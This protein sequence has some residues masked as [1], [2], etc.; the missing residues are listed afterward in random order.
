MS[1][2]SDGALGYGLVRVGLGVNLLLHGLVRL[3]KLG[4][5]AAGLQQ[6]FAESWLP[7]PLVGAFAHALPVAELLIGFFLLLGWFSRP[8]LI[9]GL[10]LLVTLT[11]GSCLIENWG[12]AGIQLTYLAVLGGLLGLRQRWNQLSVDAWMQRRHRQG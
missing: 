8:A 3:P 7:G 9:G 1:W 12:A 6:E 4:A 2:I 10:L 5:F 11:F